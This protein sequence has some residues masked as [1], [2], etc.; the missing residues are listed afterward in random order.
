M[1]PE[2]LS[3]PDRIDARSDV[4]SLGATAYF[5][6]TGRPVF[7]GAL[8]EVLAQL[9]KDKP[10]SPSTRLGRSLPAGIDA[11]VLAALAKKPEDRPESVEAFHAALLAAADGA[12]WSARDA[13]A[14]W[15]GRSADIKSARS[16]GNLSKMTGS[17][18]T[19]D[20]VRD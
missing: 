5:L 20:I 14:W 11:V 8:G 15:R 4:Y 3:S 13:E 19:L 12:G 17:P 1:A 9:L 7:E 18:P 6:L 10:P 16:G 2:A